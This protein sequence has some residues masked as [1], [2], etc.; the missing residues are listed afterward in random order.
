MA[1]DFKEQEQPEDKLL[2]ANNLIVV[3]EELE[4]SVFATTKHYQFSAKIRELI[5]LSS[6]VVLNSYS[7][8]EDAINRLEEFLR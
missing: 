5:A 6:E 4:N 1:K 2:S 3:L 8:Q 7:D